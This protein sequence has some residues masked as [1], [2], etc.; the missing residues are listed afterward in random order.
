MKF[1]HLHSF[2]ELLDGDTFGLC[3]TEFHALKCFFSAAG[4]EM[5]A[6]EEDE[7]GV[8]PH[9]KTRSSNSHTVEYRE[10]S[11]FRAKYLLYS[12]TELSL[13]RNEC[14]LQGKKFRRRFR[15][16][17]AMLEAIRD[18]IIDLCYAHRNKTDSGGR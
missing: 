10:S 16:T 1:T 11:L 6:K 9:R 14:S 2:L 15:I 3:D 8:V 7:N 12:N 18:E 5:N 4:D 13:L 17:C